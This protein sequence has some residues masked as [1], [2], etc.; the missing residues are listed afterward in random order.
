[1]AKQPKDVL[2]KD[3]RQGKTF[4]LV[5]V[6]IVDGTPSLTR[7][8]RMKRYPHRPGCWAN[9]D[10]WG[11]ARVKKV[12]R[13]FIHDRVWHLEALSILFETSRLFY[14]KRDAQAYYDLVAPFALKKRA[15]LE[16]RFPPSI[17]PAKNW[18]GKDLAL[19]LAEVPLDPNMIPNR[20]K[21]NG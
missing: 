11:R 21:I 5:E 19:T 16:A 1:M 4:W 8:D 6:V 3:V 17:N 18:I 7:A 2:K 12:R 15:E 14:R 9:A 20:L 13:I 10:A